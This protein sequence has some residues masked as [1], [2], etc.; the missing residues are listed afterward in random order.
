MFITV[1]WTPRYPASAELLSSD[2]SI[3]VF[4]LK[5]LL[6]IDDWPCFETCCT[7]CTSS[8]LYFFFLTG[9]FPYLT[10]KWFFPCLSKIL[11][12]W[13]WSSES[14]EGERI[15]LQSRGEDGLLKPMGD[16]SDLFLQGIGTH[17][18]TELQWQSI[19][20]A[21]SIVTLPSLVPH[22]CLALVILVFLVGWQ[23]CSWSTFLYFSFKR[24]F[25]GKMN[26]RSSQKQSMKIC[27]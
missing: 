24:M 21:Q 6:T 23:R 8:C 26:L 19:F 22:W 1:L 27:K 25:G 20:L 17:F 12:C 3:N 13:D 11:H 5:I 7:A 16:H 10:W 9:A 4:Y 18:C 15:W 2:F 14:L